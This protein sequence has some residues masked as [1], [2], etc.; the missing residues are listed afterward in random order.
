MNENLDL[1]K[2]LKNCPNGTKL[3]SKCLGTVK[4]NKVIQNRYIEIVDNSGRF[5]LY[6][7]NG[8]LKQSSQDA[9]IDLF[10]SKDQYDWS[11][12]Q[13]PFVDGDFVVQD[14]YD[15]IFILKEIKDVNKSDYRGKCYIGYDYK[16]CEIY[17]KG[18][19]WFDKHATEEE[20][21]RLIDTLKE[22]GY[23]WDAEKKE[24]KKIEPKFDINTLQPF[25]KVIGRDGNRDIWDID[26]FSH[27]DAKKADCKYRCLR[28]HWIQCVPYNDETKHLIGT[29]D[30]AP[31]KYIN[32]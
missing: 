10:P 2:V 9:E 19:W 5:I 7:C 27:Y 23:E 16:N 8:K 32:W 17:P 30:K 24:L 20:K 31:E 13:R 22:N 11:K 29:T 18:D 12:W 15:Q 3:Y 14:E 6:R 26:L 28:E 25:D 21:Q 4:F 1:V